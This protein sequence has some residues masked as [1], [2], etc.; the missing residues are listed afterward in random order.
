MT[1][2]E[3]N[4]NFKPPFWLMNKHAQTVLASRPP[5]AQVVRRLW[6]NEHGP[7]ARDIILDCGAGV[8]L[9]G[10]YSG[11]ASKPNGRLVVVIH[12]WEGSADS[13]YML[14]T[15]SALLAAGY[16]V[17][18]LNL[19]DHGDSHHL[20]E[21]LFHSC[22]LDEVCGA[23]A[24][25]QKLFPEQSVSLAGFSL[26]GN[27]ALRVVAEATQR[28][29]R[30]DKVV[31]ICP[32]LNPVQTM[33]ALDGGWFVYKY[34][35]LRKWRHSLEKKRALFP[36][37]YQ[38]GDLRKFKTLTGMTDYFVRNHTDYPDLHT[39]LN[40]Y[41]VTG[42]RLADLRVPAI[43]LLADDDPVIPIDGLQIM[44]ASSALQLVRTAR[45]G[46]CGFIEH[47]GSHSW[48]DQFVVQ[49]MSLD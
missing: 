28:G 49:G 47:F 33:A 5:R 21:E 23:V 46:H 35:F 40:G 19:R 27:F 11:P 2:V 17:F 45:G 38:F 36:Q 29:L 8:R 26:G 48:L 32:L 16:G 18:R 42:D 7:E 13:V 1:F 30:I 25:I 12:G 24:A 6:V 10:H 31:A 43:A 4:N 34:F 15:G 14:S 22:R 9:L 39:Y 44:N 20:N 37:L 3:N 41:A